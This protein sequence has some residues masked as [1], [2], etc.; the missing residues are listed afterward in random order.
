MV[1]RIPKWTRALLVPL[2][3]VTTPRVEAAGRGGGGGGRGGGGAH[4]G[5]GGGGFRPAMGGG[6]GGFRPGPAMGGGGFRPAAG[7]FNN[8]GGFRPGVAGNP[9]PGVRPGGFN[10]YPGGAGFTHSPSLTEPRN[11]FNNLGGANAFNRG[12]NVNNFNNVNRL[13]NNNLGFNRGNFNN[14]GPGSVGRWNGYRPYSGYHNNWV[15]GY[16]PGHY[17]GYGLGGY[18][19][20]GYGGYGYGAGGLGLGLLAGLG[21]GGL[22]AWG[23]NP[24]SYGWG[25]SN[26]ANPFYG[27]QYASLYAAQPA[28]AGGVIPTS[29]DYGVPL[30]TTS[31]PLAE[32][33]V[34][35]ELTMLDQAR[36][37]FKAGD[38][39]KALE[40]CDQAI[41]AAPNDADAHEL[42]GLA[43]FAMGQYKAAATT[44]Y[45]V[46]AS[47]PGW[48]WTTLISLYPNVDVYTQQLRALEQY[49][50]Q[51]PNDPSARFDLAYLYTSQGANE[52]AAAEYAALQKLMPND[53]LI[54]RLGR[55]VSTPNGTPDAVPP[56]ENPLANAAP[57][58]PAS[59]AVP[60]GNL[61]GTWKASPNANTTITLTYNADGS[62]TWDVA[63]NGRSKPIKGKAQ[64][65]DGVLAL[66]QENG[67]P[68][69]GKLT[70]D[71]PDKFNFRLVG[72][73]PEDPGLSFS[74]AS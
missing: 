15:N 31:A 7:N 72:N 58:T 21:I 25:Y 19:G 16:W 2:V 30:D 5:G 52:A 71:G 57:A 70:W 59:N 45:A 49:R 63:T 10:P 29:Y 41:K 47:G 46:L 48:D 50:T 42:R 73:G 26:Y 40:L 34:A 11:G 37:A 28:Y 22:G 69:A 17:G 9:A 23:M 64:F 62:Y 13:G 36:E 32:D 61:A 14:L 38:Y 56:A 33:A 6:G 1:R 65:E 51:N 12:G 66:T 43:L 24:Y 18:G 55:S 44:L 35:P 3:L 60:A 39:P 53:P 27:N 74:R 20:Y 54:A 67:P 8:G 4:V 68:L